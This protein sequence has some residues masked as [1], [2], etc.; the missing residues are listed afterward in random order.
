MRVLIAVGHSG[1]YAGGAH[2]ALYSLSGLKREGIDVAAIWGPDAQNDPNGFDRLKT[3][4][5]PLWIL[6]I[7]RRPTWQSIKTFR[8]I[9]KEFNPDV[10]E[11]I[12]SGAQYHALAAGLGLNKHA[13]IFYRGISRKMDYFQELKYRLNRVDKIIANCNGLRNIIIENGRIPP[14]KVEVVYGEFD[15]SCAEP[16]KIDASDLRKEW[17]LEP[18]I[19][20]ITQLGNYAPWRGQFITLN[21]AKLL[22]QRGYRF[23]LVFCGRETEVLKPKVEELGLSAH[24]ILS[25]YRRDPEKVLKLTDIAVNA[26]TANESLSGALLNSQAMGVPAV[27]TRITGSDE[28]IEDGV[29]GWLVPLNDV[30]ALTNKL[31]NLL[32]LTPVE[33]AEWGKRAQ[34]RARQLFSSKVKISKRIEIY[35]EAISIRKNKLIGRR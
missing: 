13:L 21:A 23:Y 9:L 29:T 11:A 34:Q 35:K 20:V 31:A 25:K 1:I 33:L 19:P 6:P 12:K 28:I 16:D 22:K 2:Q 30:E 26:S 18:N 4:N 3:L 14:K 27:A 24:V 32:D 5:I 17:G 7:H 15:P 10:L 8:N